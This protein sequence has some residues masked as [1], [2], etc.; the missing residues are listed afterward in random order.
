MGDPSDSGNFMKKFNCKDR[1][2]F[3]VLRARMSATC[4]HAVPGSSERRTAVA[5]VCPWRRTR[6]PQSC[7]YWNRSISSRLIDN[8]VPGQPYL[9]LSIS[10]LPCA[11]WP[12]GDAWTG[13]QIVGFS[14]HTIHTLQQGFMSIL[15]DYLLV[16]LLPPCLSSVSACHDNAYSPAPPGR[17]C[18]SADLTFVMN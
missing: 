5:F 7:L 18:R 8:R 15:Q 16:H 4:L 2:S 1:L 13:D 3:E 11:D 10:L 9:A 17:W 14:R 12:D 6:D